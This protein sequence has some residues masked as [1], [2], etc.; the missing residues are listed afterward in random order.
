VLEHS[1]RVQRHHL[2]VLDGEVVPGALQVSNLG[3]AQG[4]V[5]R[6]VGFAPSKQPR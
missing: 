6:S 1:R 5:V 3:Q 4:D 2:V